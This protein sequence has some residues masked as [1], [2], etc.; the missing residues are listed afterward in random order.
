[1]IPVHLHISGF[2]S[3][4]SPIDLDFTGFSLACIS[5]SNGAG[6]SSLLDAITWALFE[7]ARR[8]DESIINSN[9]DV[10]KAEVIFDFQYENNLYRVRRIKNK[11]KTGELDF[12]IRQTGAEGT[13][14]WKSLTE[15][16]TRETE[17]RIQQILRMDYETFTNA[18]F[19]LQGRADQFTQQ[20]P[21]ERKRI[22]ANIL[23]LDVWEEYRQRTADRRKQV[24]DETLVIQ[25]RLAEIDAELGEEEAREQKLQELESALEQAARRR[26]EQDV[27]VQNYRK[28]ETTL[29]EQ[30]KLIDALSRQMDNS[31]NSLEGLESE[32]I[33]RRKERDDYIRHLEKAA[34]IETAYQIWQQSRT[35]LEQWDSVAERFR[36]QENGRS[37]LLTAIESARSALA[38]EQ[39]TLLNQQQV[40]HQG[41]LELPDKKQALDILQARIA[42]A[43]D[44]A[45]QREKLDEDLSALRQS[46]ADAAAENPRLRAEMEEMK[47]RIDH[48]TAVEGAE[49]PLCGQPL[50]P[51]HRV[52]LVEEIGAEGKKMGE[53]YRLNLAL[54]HDYETRLS[55]LEAERKNLEETQKEIHQIEIQAAA[56]ATRIEQMEHLQTDWQTI[57]AARLA[58]LTRMLESEQYAL[59][60]RSAMAKIDES[61]KAIGYDASAHDAARKRE[62]DGRSSEKE[63]RE[64]ETARAALVPIE[65]TLKNLDAQIA[66]KQKETAGLQGDYGR[67][68]AALAAASAGMPDLREAERNLLDMKEQENRIRMEVGAAR[69]KVDVLGDLKIRRGDLT[70]QV[71]EKNHLTAS[72]KKLEK[73]FGKDGVPAL[74]IEQALPEIETQ[75]NELLD[76]LSNGSMSVRFA[77]QKDYRDKKRDDKKETLDI[78]IS[79]PSG[80]RDYELFSGGEAFRVNFAI[81]LAL[82]RVL[83]QRAGAR[84]QT[85]VIDEGFGSQD[86]QGRQRLIEAINQVKGD[87][88]KILIV[89]HLEELKDAFPTRIEVE[90]TDSG[91]MVRVVG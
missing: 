88:A 78:L 24:E 70:H 81:R 68:A 57:G 50:T 67:A 15:K 63:L 37:G 61:L 26:G 65:S 23:G 36:E 55:T 87:F 34:E 72:L 41:L 5:G 9:E 47:D 91:S 43:A 62:Q 76:R 56:L 20:R 86:T 1:M 3:Y 52:Q 16:S 30:R 31:Q 12:F 75:A 6:K 53:K 39:L 45:I 82:S 10:K 7:E 17:V 58:E 27:V 83:A 73:A 38:Q 49:C 71:G 25:T 13:S 84:L 42:S 85:L 80:T 66:Q 89:T 28:L 74:L 33:T 40:V 8:H 18:S 21:G 51:D 35:D 11:G 59:E 48:L 60:A 2:L 14:D 22:L 54:M 46:Q 79:D 44:L 4:R 19:F 64:L 69:Q 32:R 90:K 29:A 77:T